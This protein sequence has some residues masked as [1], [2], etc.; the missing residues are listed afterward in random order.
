MRSTDLSPDNSEV[1][2]L[3]LGLGLENVRDLLTEVPVYVGSALQSL[4]VHKRR[5]V[6]VVSTVGSTSVF[7]VIVWGELRNL[8]LIFFSRTRSGRRASVLYGE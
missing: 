4:D 1:R 3:L 2:V 8:F 7:V 6:V 5:V